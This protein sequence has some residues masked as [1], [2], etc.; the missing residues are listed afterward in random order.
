MPALGMEHQS[1]NI[2]LTSAE[3]ENGRRYMEQTRTSV[4]DATRGLSAAQW[5]FQPGPGR[6]SIAEIVEHVVIVQERVLGPIMEGLANGGAPGYA[7]P[8][9]VDAIVLDRFPERTLKFPAPEAVRPAG[10]WTPA[11]ALDRLIANYRSLTGR[12]ESSTGLRHHAIESPPLIAITQ[13]VHRHMDGYQWLLAAAAH[14]E[15]H[16]RQILE[17]KAD[18]NFPAA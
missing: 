18:P 11:E 10:R 6:W 15:R 2:G 9:E 13:G 17:V 14:T 1:S 16:T 7:D 8:K 3:L 4:T 5:S 12:L